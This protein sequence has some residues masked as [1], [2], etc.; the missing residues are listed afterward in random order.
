MAYVVMISEAR[1]KK[2]TSIDTNVEPDELINFIVQAQDLKIQDILGTYFYNNLKDRIAAGT[3]TADEDTLLNEYIAP[4]IANYAYYYAI[5]S[6]NFKTKNKA[7]L[8]PTSEESQSVGLESIKFVRQQ[9]LDTAQFYE[10]R[11]RDYLCDYSNLFPD[12][13][14]VDGKGMSPSPARK[15][16]AGFFTPTTVNYRPNGYDYPD[17]MKNK[18]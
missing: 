1:L 16:T 15:S 18:K 3:T 17:Y 9:V 4:T 11:L 14:N 13:S 7:I 6:L 10:S 12:Y 5:P 2:I 8:T